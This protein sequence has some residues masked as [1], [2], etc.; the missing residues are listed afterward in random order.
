MITAPGLGVPPRDGVVLLFWQAAHLQKLVLTP[1]SVLLSLFPGPQKLIQKRYD[2]L[3][4][5][6][7]YL[8]RA[9]ADESD[10]A[11]REYEALN[12]QLVEELQVFNVA[13]RRVLRNC[14]CSFVTRLRD[15]MAAA[16]R[17]HSATGPVSA[18]PGSAR[19]HAAPSS[20]LT[21]G[22]GVRVC[23]RVCTCVHVGGVRFY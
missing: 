17:A 10:L 18:A 6:N 5:Y 14:L 3:L 9:A 16:Q 22:L 12:A 15:L 19:K 23:A 1:L 13:A 21:A 4:D 2:K 8:Q 7:S 20:L 11:K